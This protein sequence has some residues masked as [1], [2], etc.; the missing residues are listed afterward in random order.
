MYLSLLQECSDPDVAT[1]LNIYPG[2]AGQKFQWSL[3][4]ET[5]KEETGT[6]GGKKLSY[7]LVKDLVISLPLAPCAYLV[8]DSVPQATGACLLT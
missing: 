7:A 6:K 4:L 8:Y 3:N 5:T 2:G 1:G